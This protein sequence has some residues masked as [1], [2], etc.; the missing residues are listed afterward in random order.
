MTRMLQGWVIVW[1]LLAGAGAVWAQKPEV[2]PPPVTP[3]LDSPRATLETFLEAMARVAAGDDSAMPMAQACFDTPLANRVDLRGTAQQ[4]HEVID[5]LGGINLNLTPT[6]DAI[7]TLSKREGFAIKRYVVFPRREHAWVWDKLG[8][9]PDGKIV[10]VADAGDQ[11]RFDARTVMGA[12]RLYESMKDLPP[13]GMAVPGAVGTGDAGDPV[14]AMLGP[15]FDRTP[16]WGWALLLLAIFLGLAAGKITQAF[17][18]GM[19]ERFDARGWPTRAI[20]IRDLLSPVSMA[21][22]ATGVLLGLRLIHMEPGVAMFSHR[23]IAF[24]YLIAIAWALYNLVEVVEVGLRSIVGRTNNK[25]D[26]MLLPL[27]RK[28]L[29]IFLLI[30]FTLV[31]AQNVFGLNITGWLAGL[32]IAGLAVSL[33]AQDSVKN[34]FGSITV[35]LDKPFAVGDRI[36][37]DGI[38]GT[39]E[40]IGFRSTRIRTLVGHVVTVPNMKFIDNNVENVN[41]RRSLRRMLDVTVTY[42]TPLEKIEQGIQIIK[43]ILAEPEFV[44]PFDMEKTPPRVFF[45]DYNAA[46]LNIRVMYWYMLTDGRDWWS[47]NAYSERFN[48]RLFKAFGDAGIEFAFPTQTLYLAGDPSRTLTVQTASANS[49]GT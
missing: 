35:L 15:T 19:A 30:I 11:W 32:G 45:N 21:M 37:F 5:R 28:S 44:E 13:R 34:L 1:A 49:G 40:E 16:W 17:L 6:A 18:K 25:L 8:K 22:L 23:V 4:L 36:V 43:S 48:L 31:V 42:D 26:D 3:K 38:D 27:V 29:R 46:S 7:A 20:A 24:L 41:L 12:D 9:A 33:A 47:Y 39:V 10:L 2:P 14:F